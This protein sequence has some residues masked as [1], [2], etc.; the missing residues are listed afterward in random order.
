MKL[1]EDRT[2]FLE[3]MEAASEKLE[4]RQVYLEKDYWVTFVLKEL[5]NSKFCEGVVFKGGTSLSKAYR[6]VERFSEDIDLV[7]LKKEGMSGNQIKNFLSELESTIIKIPVIADTEFKSSKGSKIRKTGYKYPRIVDE[8]DFGHA[9]DT[10]ILELNAFANPHPINKMKIQSY[11]T[12]FLESESDF[13]SIAKYELESFEVNVLDATRT[14]TEKVMSLARICNKDDEK[15]TETKG[16]IRHFYDIHKLIESGILKEFLNSIEFQNTINL[17][18]QDDLSNPEFR[19]D[20]KDG[21]LLETKLF[22]NVDNIIDNL[23]STY[24]DNFETLLYKPEAENFLD[25]KKSFTELVK[26]IPD[27]EI[28]RETKNS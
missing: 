8:E 10:L 17:V 20:W 22:K 4:I 25:I 26:L 23:K 14:F 28:K 24:K 6:V 16:K 13:I 27:I 21:K 7:L 3:I 12:D 9:V 11:A 2:K 19:E 18:L 1:H 5:S 15:L